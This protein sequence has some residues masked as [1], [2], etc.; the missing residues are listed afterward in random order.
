[1]T[2]PKTKSSRLQPI[3]ITDPTSVWEVDERHNAKKNSYPTEYEDHLE[4]VLISSKNIRLRTLNISQLI[5]E[6][7]DNKRPLLLYVLQSNSMFFYNLLSDLQKLRFGYT[8]DFI[9]TKS[10]EGHDGSKN[11]EITSDSDLSSV[12]DRDVII[13]EDMIDKGES[14]KA[15]MLC[16]EQ[17]LPKSIQI[18][19]FLEKRS[20]SREKKHFFSKY[21]GFSIPD[22]FVVGYGMNYDK[23]YRNLS[24]IWILSKKVINSTVKKNP[25]E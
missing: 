3:V 5:A 15:I 19:S 21:A 22:K 8:Y 18:C 12:R 17:F 6:D 13:V 23:K 2:I 9:R 7:Y 14:T 24:D 10:F 25:L 1:M 16:L 4:N 11:Y 20:K